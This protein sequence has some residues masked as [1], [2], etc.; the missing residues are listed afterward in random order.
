MR[1]DAPSTRTDGSPNGTPAAPVLAVALSR[2][3]ATPPSWRSASGVGTRHECDELAAPLDR[4]LVGLDADH[5]RLV[6]RQDAI[7]L[8]EHPLVLGSDGE[9]E[10]D[11]LVG[12]H[13]EVVV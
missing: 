7:E 1:P 11:D 2:P 13:G 12:R 9:V 3:R 8:L 5:A 10:P 6:E 4:A